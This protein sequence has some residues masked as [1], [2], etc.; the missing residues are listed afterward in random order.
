MPGRHSAPGASSTVNR[1]SLRY[2]AVLGA[3]LL[4]I[5]GGVFAAQRVLAFAGCES[6]GDVTVSADPALVPVLNSVVSATSPEDLGCARLMIVADDADV[7]SAAVARGDGPSLWIP[8][9]SES[10]GKVAASTGQ[11]VDIASRSIAASPVV[12]AARTGELPFF[13]SWLTALQLPTLRL[14]N[15]LSNSVSR[16]PVQ[17][18]LA[19]ASGKPGGVDAVSTALVP[20]AQAMAGQAPGDSA[21]RLAD[22]ADDGGVAVASEQQVVSW[23]GAPMAATAPNTGAGVLDFPIAVTAPVGPTRDAAKAAGVALADVMRSN[24]ARTILSDNGFRFPDLAPLDE[25]RGVG[26]VIALVPT[27]RGVVESALRRFSVLALPTRGIVLEDVSGSMGDAV[28]GDTRIGLTVKASATGVGLFPDN[29][30]LG[31]WAFSIGLGGGSQD[32][33]ELVPLRT[34]NEVADGSTGRQAL[35]NAIGTLPA[36]VGGGTGLYDT[37]LAAWRRIKEGYDPTAYNSVIVLTDGGDDDQNGID[38]DTL[39]Q[40]L[41]SEQDPAKPVS[42]VTIGITDDADAGTL[43][44]I[45]AA[46]GG[47]SFVARN[48]AEIPNVFVTASKSRNGG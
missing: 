21:A 38:L 33:R 13:D 11:L 17:A 23:A 12:I 40:T 26:D 8:D 19:E 1:V 29:A 24:A 20:I 48:P 28:G 4:V 34:L 15:P 2:L 35:T 41:K 16:A 5:V 42:I 18:A 39:L 37:T 44:Q 7:T 22:V 43:Q 45:S 14:G 32:W 31:L 27:D 9:S 6:T 10:I 25:G 46:T 47:T 30:S 3:A 36:L